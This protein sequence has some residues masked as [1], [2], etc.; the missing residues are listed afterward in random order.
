MAVY[1][2]TQML[3]YDMFANR[4]GLMNEEG[5]WQVWEVE[6]RIHDNDYVYV[7]VDRT[8][9]IDTDESPTETFIEVRAVFTDSDDAMEFVRADGMVE[10]N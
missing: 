4:C 5:T 9:I 3:L 7:V 2:P 10:S 8:G 1:E 6:S